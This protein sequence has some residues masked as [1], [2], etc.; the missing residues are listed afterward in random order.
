MSLTQAG[1]HIRV[2]TNL[3]EDK[4]FLES[5]EGE[6]RVSDLF[7]FE[8]GV[9]T[10]DPDFKMDS[11]LNQPAVVSLSL[12]DDT[13]RNF[14][15]IINYMEEVE[16]RTEGYV[17]YRATMV[18]WAWLLTLF[19]DCRIFQNK[20]VPDI[21]Q[22][23]FTDRGFSD[24]ANRLTGTYSPREYTVQYRETDL[25]FISRLLEDEGIFYFFEHTADKHTLV[26]A[27][28]P[29]AF[30]A[31]P[32]QDTAAYDTTAG[33]WQDPDVVLSLRR[34]QQVRVRK[35]TENDYDFTKPKS[36]LDANLQDG[37][38][39]AIRQGEFYEYPGKYTVRDE[40]SRYARVRLEEQEVRLLTVTAETNCRAF[41]AGF[42]F[43]LS[44]YFRDDAN[45]EYAL[46]VVN[47][48][49]ASN[50]HISTDMPESF[51]Y[52]NTVEVIPASIP[53]HPP[54][55]AR[56]PFIQGSQTA[57]VVGKSGEEIWVD[58]YGRVKVQFFWDRAGNMD[59]NSSCWIRVAQLWAGKGWGAIF[60]PRIG[61][62]VI[63]DFLEGDPDRPIITG[64]VYNA[65]QTVPYTLPDEQTK[66]TVKSMSSKGGGGFNEI[67]LED[68]KGSEQVFIHGEKDED[69]RIKNDAREWIGED[70]SL[71]VIRDQMEKIGRDSHGHFMRDQIG[72][73]ERDH[74]LDIEGK[75][76]I[77]IV[78]SHSKTVQGDVIEVFQ[79]N[80]ST[81][82]TQNVYIKGMQVVIEA[83]TGLTIKVGGNFVTID[84]SG[85]T[86]LGTMVN[87][88]SGG[89]ALSGSAG[90]AVS[91][92]SP[93]DPAV[94]DDATP[95][96]NDV[97]TATP[98]TLATGSASNVSPITASS[99]A[100]KSAAS[101]APTHDPNAPENQEKKHWI[102]IQLNDEDGKPVPGEAY[103]VTLPDGTTVAD[104]TLDDKG[105]ARVDNID[106]GTCQVTFPN[107]DKDAWSPQ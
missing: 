45:Q 38:E 11:L 52:R 100:P 98:G 87:I 97:P 77:K 96:Q 58:Q 73:V 16:T 7:R 50:P 63:V 62:E 35:I 106:P 80:Q 99:A 61:Q 71:I 70:R 15:G 104:G 78:G 5:F 72:K 3:G 93:T 75:E 40:G 74:H 31:C 83:M 54:R 10:A 24:Y 39:A 23:V 94:A 59:E 2:N 41:C 60:T 6:E 65:N 46:L 4:L 51:D 21:V 25:N 1:R 67:R 44:G 49:A 86:I 69:I 34:A 27:D 57:V 92:L 17:L 42:K 85:V 55:H 105:F 91:P 88:N 95:G 8:L 36:P 102:E 18:P 9:L 84:S 64:R 68:K 43:T 28:Q 19:N 22:Q 82:V 13:D 47:H 30:A 33:G 79:G 56:R 29:S 107:L 26:L 53:Y 48:R 89:A 12:A 37:T 103:K 32:G 76:A 81:Q 20:S 14:H 101:D 90:S 66:S